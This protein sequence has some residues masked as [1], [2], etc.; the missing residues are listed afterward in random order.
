MIRRPPRSTRVR[1]SA[2]SDVYKRQRPLSPVRWDPITGRPLLVAT[3]RTERP[4]DTGRMAP[5]DMF[6]PDDGVHDGC[7]FCPG[8]ERE[9]P[10][11]IWAD[12]AP[13]TLPN[14]PGWRVRAIPN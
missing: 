9:T 1:S 4:H 13:G 14:T 7:P 11:E 2:A 6:P 12:R 3:G 5:S 10:P 8:A